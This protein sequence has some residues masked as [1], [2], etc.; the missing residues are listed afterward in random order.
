[1]KKV[2]I[3]QGVAIASLLMAAQSGALQ[4]TE[5][6]WYIS[7]MI[8]YID[9]D[10]DRN[11]DNDIG[12]HLGIGKYLNQRWS[13]EISALADTLDSQTDSTEYQQRGLIAD[14][15]Y[16]FK[17]DPG[18]SLYGVVG[19]GAL[20][21]KLAGD[22]DTQLSANIGAGAIK[23][24][25]EMISLR[26]DIRYRLDE[27]DR[28]PGEQHLGE[29]LINVGLLIPFGSSKAQPGSQPAPEAAATQPRDATPPPAPVVVDTDGDGTPDSKDQCA[30]TPA[31]MAVDATGCELDSDRDGV[32]D[33]RDSCPASPSGAQVDERGCE[34]D[35]DGDGVSDSR[36]DCP[37]TPAGTKVTQQGCIADSDGDGIS[38]DRDNCPATAAG[39]RVDSKGCELEETIV[40]KGV[41][42][43]S[44]STQLSAASA[45]ALDDIA[46]TLRK[47]ETMV[48]EVSG[49][50]DNRGA[51]NFNQRLSAKRAQAVVDYLISKGVKPAN[52]RARGYGSSRPIAENSSAAGRAENRRVELQILQR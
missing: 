51:E 11:A 31:G 29:W 10:S 44:G 4:A 41:T 30:T 8:S 2:S 42:F 5:Q 14:G 43:E 28:V 46:A 6:P 33:S 24:I 39:I 19:M 47:Y 48:V 27:E 45:A 15:L 34:L 49:H 21:T 37:N 35:S 22:S 13:V 20:R 50:T 1:M 17:R 7:P 25:N 32:A 16:F 3:A 40:L 36:D 23:P 18:L 52:L 12:L 26:G 9:A 38:D